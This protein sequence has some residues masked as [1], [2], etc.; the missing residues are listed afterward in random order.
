MTTTTALASEPMP[1]PYAETAEPT[2]VRPASSRWWRLADL[3]VFGI[4]IALV[5][6]TLR[7]HE[8]WVDEAQAW[9]FARDLNLRTLWFYELRYEGSPGLWHTI[10][11]FAQH[12]FH[13]RYAT[14]GLFGM[15]AATGGVALLIFKAP[16]PRYI[17][18]PLAFTYF[19]VYQYAVIARQYT[20]LP[21]L[22]F[23]AAILF[24]D[25]Q[26]PLRMTA[27]LVLL[28]NVSFHGTIL[29]GC[30]GLAYLMD[31]YQA[32]GTLDPRLRK[33]YL[34]GIGVMALTFVFVYLVLKPPHDSLEMV[35]KHGVLNL[36]RFAN[37]QGQVIDSS[38]KFTNVISGAFFDQ[39]ALSSIFLVL[40]AAWCFLRRRLL[41]FVLAV[42]LEIA[43]YSVIYGTAHH[44]GTVFL[45]AITSL[46]IAWPVASE[47]ENFSSRDRWALRGMVALLLCLCAV[48]IWDAGV[49]I[50]RDYLYPYSGAED[51]ANYLKA[52]GAERA[53]IFG[54]GFGI[55]AVQAYFDHKVMA[56]IP[57][58]YTHNGLP[59]YGSSLNVAELERVKPEY[60]VAFSVVPQEM[61]DEDGPLMAS[62]GYEFVHF[63]DGYYFYK[64]GVYERETYFIFRRTHS[65]EER[66]P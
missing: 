33:Q 19:L 11:W 51:A 43:L 18:W 48:N 46:W 44:H 9:L 54:L 25:L 39:P 59:G 63:S 13:A 21:L 27:V 56:N 26:H 29:A 31:A 50:R 35:D 7:H 10:L 8:K 52:V 47:Q 12:I 45:A 4:W 28:A 24:K 15:A 3:G 38:L 1:I 64:R 40:A 53:P 20:L 60:I 62:L 55:S 17:R 36:P 6:V 23:Y 57:T 37:R 65:A 16:F 66:R 61:M 49:T 2:A 58:S 5:G 30:I 34:I 42:G 22:A 41:L 14:L 32:R